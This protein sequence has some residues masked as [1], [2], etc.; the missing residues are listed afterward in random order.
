MTISYT[1]RNEDE[2][3]WACFT[4]NDGSYMEVPIHGVAS[5]DIQTKLQEAVDQ[6]NIMFGISSSNNP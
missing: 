6:Y 5:E 4:L 2:Y 1:E 3:T